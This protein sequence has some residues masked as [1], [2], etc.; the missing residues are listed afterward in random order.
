MRHVARPEWL[1]ANDADPLAATGRPVRWGVV[2]T[3]NIADKVTAQLRQLQDVELVA[4]SSRSAERAKAFAAKHGFG[5]W[6]GDD[7]DDG[8]GG[9]D[10][11]DGGRTGYQRL[12]ED[13]EVE[14]VYVATPHG[15]HHEVASALLRSGKH[16]LVE[17]AFTINAREARELAKLAAEGGLFLMEAMWTRFL[18]A[19]QHTLDV[20]ERGDIGE[21]A[22]VQAELGFMAV[23]DPRSR[24]WARE[25]GGGALLDLAVYPLTWALGALGYPQSVHAAG[26]LNSEGVDELEAL[27]LTYGDGRQAQLLTSLV[28]APRSRALIVGSRGTIA[29]E[30]SLTRPSGIA[31]TTAVNGST[32][33]AEVEPFTTD[34]PLYAHQLR[35]VTRCVQQ[36]LTE[37]PTM[38]LSDSVRTMVLL[39]EARRQIGVTYPNDELP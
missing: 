13:P 6:Y 24:L 15:Q 5:R 36:G 29:T 32:G 7:V 1:S 22:Y 30:G 26:R 25:A 19:F 9:D 8:D 18:P 20:I 2:S 38:P 12:A 17:K 16:L 39:D 21:V 4:V 11:D 10:G 31:V 37:S 34:A 14:V 27:T 23:G 28:T 35:E 33:G 3:G